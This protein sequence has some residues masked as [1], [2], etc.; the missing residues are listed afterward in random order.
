M[1]KLDKIFYFTCA[2]GAQTPY[3]N[4]SRPI[5]KNYM[6]HSESSG[7]A[8]LYKIWHKSYSCNILQYY[9][10]VSFEL[11]TS[12]GIKIGHPYL[13]LQLFRMG[14]VAHQR[15]RTYDFNRLRSGVL[16][17][18]PSG[19]GIFNLARVWESLISREFAKNLFLIMRIILKY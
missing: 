4:R 9:N 1:R 11:K 10:I 7:T 19:M 16:L 8:I 2:T 17:S 6:G 15:D 18:S 14:L 12:K 13:A 5:L 3:R